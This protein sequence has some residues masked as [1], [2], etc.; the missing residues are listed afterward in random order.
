MPKFRVEKKRNFTQIDNYLFR[1]RD[2]SLKSKGLL[3]LMLSLPDDW[4]YSANGLAALNKDG[5][6]SV[7]TALNDLEKAGYLVRKRQRLSNGRLN[8]F[9]YFIYEQSKSAEI[10]KAPPEEKRPKM[11]SPEQI[12]PE[13]EIPS[14]LNKNE[15]NTKEINDMIERAHAYRELIKENIEY[16]YLVNKYDYT[17]VDEIVEIMV[18][19]LIS[20]KPTCRIEGTEIARDLVRSRYLKLDSSHIEY[21]FECIENTSSSISCIKEYLVTSL[22]NAAITKENYYRAEANHDYPIRRRP[23]QL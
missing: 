17:L 3:C 16:D 10:D 4:E 15:L 5:V 9:E 8:S 6:D 1:D 2:L 19:T 11:G 13:Q 21:L 14:E 12:S 7:K 22:Y 23:Q 18:D 20:E